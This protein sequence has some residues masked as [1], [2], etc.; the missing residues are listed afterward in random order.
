MIEFFEQYKEKQKKV[1]EKLRE[2][3]PDKNTPPKPMY[4]IMHYVLFN[5]GKRIRPILTLSVNEILNG[6]IDLALIS[7]CAV[8]IVHNS[9]LIFDD[10]PSM[11]N[12]SIRRGKLCVHKVYPEG[13]VI[14]VADAMMNFAFEILYSGLIEKDEDLALKMINILAKT[15]GSQGM[16]AGQFYDLLESKNFNL[17]NLRYIHLNKTGKLIETSVLFGVLTSQ[18]NDKILKKFSA[19]AKIIGLTFQII[20][21]ILDYEGDAERLGKL[22]GKDKE[23]NKLS[24]VSYFGLNKAKQ[25]ANKLFDNAISLLRSFKGDIEFLEALTTFLFKR[26]Y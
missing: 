11:D 13:Q 15:I 23:L 17:S 21:D 5:G 24:F 16:V 8:E 2:I 19:Y 9:S 4:E 18:Y 7:G 1:E 10:L 22:P 25:I 14:I 20:D 12:A 6:D 26:N 3:L